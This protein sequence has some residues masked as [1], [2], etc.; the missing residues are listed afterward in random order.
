MCVWINDWVNNR[1]VGDLRWYR[2]HYD[3]IV[4]YSKWPLAPTGVWSIANNWVLQCCI[5]MLSDN[6][7]SLPES[8]LTSHKWNF[9]EQIWVAFCWICYGFE[10]PIW[11]KCVYFIKVDIFP[12]PGWIDPKSI[13]T[14]ENS[15]QSCFIGRLPKYI[16]HYV[17]LNRTE[18]C[19]E[20]SWHIKEETRKNSSRNCHCATYPMSVHFVDL[21]VRHVV[22]Y[23][24]YRKH[25]SADISQAF[26]H[27]QPRLPIN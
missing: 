24:W 16:S 25:I 3:V 4:M 2:A 23:W 26:R 27:R 9:E 8:V 12:R 13:V 1:E 10:S 11:L 15:Y 5:N 6:I 17:L 22:A 20:M 21:F 14:C 7:K 19:L 18:Y